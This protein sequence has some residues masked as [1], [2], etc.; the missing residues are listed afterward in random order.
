MGVVN[1]SGCSLFGRTCSNLL[2][3]ALYIDD[4]LLQQPKQQQ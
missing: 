3:I 2:P 1:N 4:I